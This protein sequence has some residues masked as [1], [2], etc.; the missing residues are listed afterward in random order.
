MLLWMS[1]LIMVLA[2]PCRVED[3]ADLKSDGLQAYITFEYLGLFYFDSVAKVTK[4]V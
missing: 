2:L 4:F 3:V 1:G